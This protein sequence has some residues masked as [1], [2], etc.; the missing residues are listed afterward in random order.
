MARPIL[1]LFA[2]CLSCSGVPFL[3]PDTRTAA[4]HAHEVEPKCRDFG[5]TVVEPV[6]APGVIDSV[7]P[8]Y[9]Y[10]KSGPVDRE[11]RLRGARIRVKPLAGFSKEAIARSVECHEARVVLGQAAAR[12]DDPY[13]LP[14]HWIDIDVESEGDGFAILVRADEI[15]IARQLLA[16]AQR[17]SASPP[18]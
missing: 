17:Y 16:R 14:G 7:E 6:L 15:G 1:L 3:V 10:V 12:V 8:A 9:S 5:E 11:A 2:A 18:R 13:V 4:D